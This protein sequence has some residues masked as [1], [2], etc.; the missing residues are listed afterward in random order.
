MKYASIS[1]LEL[2]TAVLSVKRAGMITKEL[3][4][5]NITKYFWSGS[6]VNIGY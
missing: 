6:Q 1:R 2:A 5:E 3:A 4:I